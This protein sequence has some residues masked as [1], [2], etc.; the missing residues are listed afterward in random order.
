MDIAGLVRGA[1]GEGLGNQFL[2]H[3]RM[4]DA[5]LHVVRCFEDEITHA[6]GSIDPIRDIETIDTELV[7]ADLESMERQLERLQKKARDKT[8]RRLQKLPSLRRGMP[9]LLKLHFVAEWDEEQ[10]AALKSGG[11]ITIKPAL[12][13]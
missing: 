13:L 6:E 9:F 2:G 4:V 7:L 11:F 10:S 8:K 3:I 12:C 5:V 1:S